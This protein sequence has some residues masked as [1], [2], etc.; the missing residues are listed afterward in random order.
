MNG[1]NQEDNQTLC[2]QAQGGAFETITVPQSQ[3]DSHLA[4]GDT[5]GECPASGSR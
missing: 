3:V 1:E 2:H 5:L 4:H